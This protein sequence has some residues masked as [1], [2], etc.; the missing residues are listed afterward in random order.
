MALP[1]ANRKWDDRAGD[2]RLELVLSGMN[3]DEAALRER[4]DE[5]HRFSRD[6]DTANRSISQ[7]EVLCHGNALGANRK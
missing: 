5:P 2:A 6:T 3:M 4:F 1:R 7:H